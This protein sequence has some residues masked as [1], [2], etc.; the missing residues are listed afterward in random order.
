MKRQVREGA[1]VPAP[2]LPC[3]LLPDLLCCRLNCRSLLS[4]VY[5]T[6]SLFTDACDYK[7]P[8]LSVQSR[9]RAHLVLLVSRHNVLCCAKELLAAILDWGVFL[10]VRGAVYGDVTER[11][12]GRERHLRM[13]TRHQDTHDHP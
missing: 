9:S 11:P 7:M 10:R 1:E 2:D 13:H 6:L 5:Y 8:D 3:P 12:V 4:I